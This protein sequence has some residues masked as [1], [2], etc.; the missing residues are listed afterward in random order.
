MGKSD[1]RGLDQ[2]LITRSEPDVVDSAKKAATDPVHG[3]Y[4]RLQV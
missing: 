3:T 4:E 1:R 2:E